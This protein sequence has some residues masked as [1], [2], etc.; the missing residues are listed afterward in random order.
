MLLIMGVVVVFV[1]EEWAGRGWSVLICRRGWTVASIFIIR[2]I[3]YLHA[4]VNC[5]VCSYRILGEN[6]LRIV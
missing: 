3:T 4:C 2:E 6:S 1:R 5:T